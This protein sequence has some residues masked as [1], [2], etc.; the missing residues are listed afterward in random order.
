MEQWRDIIGYEGLYQVSDWGRVKSFC[1]GKERILV[2]CKDRDGYLR[3]GLYKDGKM[4]KCFV[5]RL[6]AEAFIPNPYGLP[7]VN[8]RDETRDNNVASN[9]EYCD[10][11]YNNA[12]GTHNER[13]AKALT[14]HPAKSRT[15]F[16]YTLDGSLVRSYPSV[17]ETE[18]RTGYDQGAIS[19]CCRGVRN[20]HMGYLWSYELLVPKGRLF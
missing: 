10:A 18:R 20:Q 11:A 16:Q 6:V 17:M 4:K 13:V 5:H 8:H 7:C 14:N 9:L 1:N 12:Y 15:V 2:G 19:K 3:V